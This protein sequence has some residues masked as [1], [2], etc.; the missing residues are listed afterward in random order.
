MSFEK[1]K[2]IIKRTK[3]AA[4]NPETVQLAESFEEFILLYDARV[5]VK[6][7]ADWVIYTKRL[8]EGRAQVLAQLEK[9]AA[10]LG[11]TVEQMQSYLANPTN[12]SHEQWMEMQGVREAQQLGAKVEHPIA[13]H[14]K[15]RNKKN[16]IRI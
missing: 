4:P 14:K 13:S 12:F 1:I 5:E 2:E 11:L 9:T 3:E 6:T 7:P 15:L 10:S 16:N 8:Q